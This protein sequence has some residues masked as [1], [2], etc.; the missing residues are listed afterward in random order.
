MRKISIDK[1]VKLIMEFNP[2]VNF[3]RS[4]IDNAEIPISKEV[5]KSTLFGI[6]TLYLRIRSFS[7]SK[8]IVQKHKM[9]QNHKGKQTALRKKL[10]QMKNP[11]EKL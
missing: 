9:M 10:K 5:A 7:H 2:I 8:D 4:V 3:F 6:L 11:E 1:L